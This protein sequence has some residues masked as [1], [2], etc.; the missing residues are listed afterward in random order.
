MVISNTDKVSWIPCWKRKKKQ[1]RLCTTEGSVVLSEAFPP[2][3][4]IGMAQYL[5]EVFFVHICIYVFCISQMFC[6]CISQISQNIVWLNES[7]SE[8]ES[9]VRGEGSLRFSILCFPMNWS[10]NNLLA[11]DQTEKAQQIMVN[12]R[13]RL[14]DYNSLPC[15]PFMHQLE[16]S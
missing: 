5:T 8:K 3:P 13:Q 4:G 1:P 6:V 14:K 7:E 15:S 10:C 9:F 2:L 11:A 12:S 16:V